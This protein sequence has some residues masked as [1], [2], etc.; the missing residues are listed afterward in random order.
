MPDIKLSRD[1]EKDE[2]TTK[3]ITIIMNEIEDPVDKAREKTPANSGVLPVKRT[4]NN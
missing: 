2:D 4:V 3:R 1:E